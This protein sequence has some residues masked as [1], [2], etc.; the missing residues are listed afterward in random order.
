MMWKYETF[1]DPK[2]SSS[3]LRIAVPNSL[4]PTQ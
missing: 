4:S 3:P 1:K 2:D